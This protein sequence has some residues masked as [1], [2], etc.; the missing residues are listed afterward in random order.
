M[1]EL[2]AFT[3]FWGSMLKVYSDDLRAQAIETH[4]LHAKRC[5][6]LF[7][8]RLSPFRQSFPMPADLIILTG[9]SAS[10]LF[11]WRIH[12]RVEKPI[13]NGSQKPASASPGRFVL[14]ET[15]LSIAG[16]VA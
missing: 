8:F 10:L 15:W 11:A 2:T 4:T 5:H 9:I 7:W 16:T 6:L 14:T 3:R 12:E 13:M 1:S